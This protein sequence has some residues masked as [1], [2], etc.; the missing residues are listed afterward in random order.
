MKPINPITG[1]PYTLAEIR[2]AQVA[3]QSIFASD[4]STITQAD[5]ATIYAVE[6]AAEAA[7]SV[8]ANAA[9]QPVA[10]SQPVQPASPQPVD[11]SVQPAPVQPAPID[12]P[13]VPSQPVA[14][15]VAVD[16][17]DVTND[18]RLAVMTEAECKTLIEFASVGDVGNVGRYLAYCL[19][20]RTAA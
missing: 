5:I 16:A 12:P 17:K 7:A 1:Q 15:A 6:L 3:G 10:T 14:A 8:T 19:G 4:G 11:T 13:F 2:A 9:P 18:D 20:P